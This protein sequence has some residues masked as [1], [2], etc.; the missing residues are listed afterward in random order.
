MTDEV[1]HAN[2]TPERCVDF[3]RESYVGRRLKHGP[4]PL[5]DALTLLAFPNDTMSNLRA[6]FSERSLRLLARAALDRYCETGSTNVGDYAD[7]RGEE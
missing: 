5:T 3:T 2:V 6:R 4:A 1:M 7:L